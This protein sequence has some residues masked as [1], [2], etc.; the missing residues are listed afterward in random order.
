MQVTLRELLLSASTVFLIV[1]AAVV[2]LLVPIA[3]GADSA[4][5]IT[6]STA[7]CMIP[8]GLFAARRMN[9]EPY[10]GDRIGWK[11]G[12]MAIFGLAAGIAA[13]MYLRSISDNPLASLALA[14]FDAVALAGKVMLVGMLGFAVV[15]AV[16]SALARR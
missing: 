14:A 16:R 15:E 13:L 6:L 10:W 12:F 9:R 1:A 4:L 5:V 2:G 3:L 8:A 7:A 11:V